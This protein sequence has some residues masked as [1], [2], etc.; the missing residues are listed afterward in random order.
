MKWLYANPIVLNLIISIIALL[1]LFVTPLA[2]V[3]IVKALFVVDSGTL[4][5]IGALTFFASLMAS[6]NWLID[7][8]RHDGNY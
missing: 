7:S 4:G 6:I 1:I 3:L 2:V 8:W 5:F